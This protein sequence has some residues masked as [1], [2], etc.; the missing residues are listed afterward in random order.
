MRV[1]LAVLAAI[2]VTAPLPPAAGPRIP[3]R[4]SVAFAQGAA[5]SAVVYEIKKAERHDPGCPAGADHFGCA[6]ITFE[7]P[8][9]VRAPGPASAAAINRAVSEFLLWRLQAAPFKDLNEEMAL[10]M[11]WWREAKSQDTTGSLAPYWQERTI[12]V[13]YE[14]PRVVSLEFQDNSFMGGPH[15]N[16]FSN[17]QNF[18]AVTGAVLRLGDILTPG[19]ELPLTRIA[20]REF[21]KAR[22][23]APDADLNQAGYQFEHNQFQLTTN[24][25]VGPGGLT[26]LYNLYAIA[27]YAQGITELHIDYAWIRD[28]I[29]PD[30]PLASLRPVN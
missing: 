18:D 12:K 7:Y 27:S 13:L 21:R 22:K 9:I 29:R 28:L 11:Q 17:Y 6:R 3:A 30:G 4:V 5:P 15:P 16:F 8:V 20:E 2:I 19:Y 10:F 23:L 14:S 1:V 24:Y 26:F 25:A